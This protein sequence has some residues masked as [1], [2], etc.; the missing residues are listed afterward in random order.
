LPNWHK[1]DPESFFA[2]F[3][4]TFLF[5]SFAKT[6]QFY[7]SWILLFNFFSLNQ[8]PKPLLN[9]NIFSKT[10]TKRQLQR[11]VNSFCF[12]LSNILQSFLYSF[13]ETIHSHS[14]STPKMTSSKSGK[15]KTKM[16]WLR[17]FFAC[18]RKELIVV[19]GWPFF[20]RQSITWG[21]FWEFRKWKSKF[22][23]TLCKIKGTLM[24]KNNSVIWNE[25]EN[26]EIIGRQKAFLVY[27]AIKDRKLQ[28]A[29]KLV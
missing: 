19:F 14:R 21:Y 23:V 17:L 25:L 27:Q 3:Y 20:G 5:L 12:R 13:P 16:T 2:I 22:F 24:Q 8:A 29:S 15:R 4:I 18:K 1:N 9:P 26:A 7:N 28:G 11:S 6:L 10:S